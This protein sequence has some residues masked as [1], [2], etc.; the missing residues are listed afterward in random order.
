MLVLNTSLS[1]QPSNGCPRSPLLKNAFN[2]IIQ[3]VEL[4]SDPQKAIKKVVM[5]TLGE[6]DYSA[7]ETMHH[8]LSLKLHSSL[9]NVVPV[10]LNGSRRVHTNH[11]FDNGNASCTSNSPLD[12][13]VNRHQYDS[14]PE[15]MNLNFV[16]FTTKYKV[17]NGKLSKLPENVVPCIFPTILPI[18]KGRIFLITASISC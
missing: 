8:L 4:N 3:N 5:K 7:H 16:Q 9:L 2:S 14:S 11:S 13:Y 10:S 15:T 18:Q 6:R 12:V 1:I 17:N